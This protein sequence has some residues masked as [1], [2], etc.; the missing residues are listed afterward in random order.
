[1][2]DQYSLY[3]VKIPNRISRNPNQMYDTARYGRSQNQ[4]LL[5]VVMFQNF[6]DQRTCIE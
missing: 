2:D 6:T 1:M 4:A 3:S 5:N